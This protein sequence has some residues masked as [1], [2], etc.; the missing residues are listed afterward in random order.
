MPSLFSRATRFSALALSSLL[1]L[2]ACGGGDSAP[3]VVAADPPVAPSPPQ[4][5]TQ[6]APPPQPSPP[7]TE[8]SPPPPPPPPSPPPSEPNPPP[9]PPEPSPPPPEL[10]LADTYT[11]LVPA[12]IGSRPAWPAWVAPPN[13]APVGGVGCLINE[14]YHIHTLVSIYR[15]G[16]RQGLPDN[17]G[18]SGCAYE[19][20][21]H[22]VTGVVHIETDVRKTFTLGQFFALWSQPLGAG[23]TAGLAGPVRFYL[24]DNEKLTPFMGDPAQIELTAHREIVII[25]GS[26]PAVLPKYRWPPG[27]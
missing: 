5:P 25:S 13:R 24:I 26:A 10:V 8:P 16:V 21:T 11:E 14:N 15:D 22:D 4:Q 19:L 18:R 12:T 23:G 6:P 2:A 1:L 20:H 3:E 27:I 9:A 7:P 17:V